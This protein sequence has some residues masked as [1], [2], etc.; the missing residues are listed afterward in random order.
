MI[1]AQIK[2][3]IL[4]ILTAILVTTSVFVALPA[5]VANAAVTCPAGFAEIPGKDTCQATD[6]TAKACPK[7]FPKVISQAPLLQCGK[8]AINPE[9][10]KDIIAKIQVLTGIQKLMNKIIWPVLVLTG[11]LMDNSLLFGN[12]MEEQL[13]NIWIPIRNLVNIFFVIL[14]VGIAL[15]NVLGIGDENSEYAVKSMLPKIVIGIIAVNFSFLAIKVVLDAINILTV[16]IFAL[17]NQVSEGLDKVIEFDENGDPTSKEHKKIESLCAS[18]S[19]QGYS[20]YKTTSDIVRKQEIEKKI[21]HSVLKKVT[22]QVGGKTFKEGMTLEE[23]K[24]FAKQIPPKGT[25][26]V[27]AKAVID[28]Q[29]AD[30]IDGNLC[31]EQKKLTPTGKEFLRSYNSRN[32]AFAMAL[33]MGKIVFYNEVNWHGLE[34]IDK[35]FINA[36]MSMLLY[37]VYVASFLALF[38]V[39][40]GRM[41]VM[42]LSIAVSPILVLLLGSSGIKEKVGDLGKLVDQFTKNAIAPVLIALSMTI[43]WIMLKAIQDS[44]GMS[45]DSAL[46]VDLTGGIPV[47]GLNTLQDFTVAVGTIAVVWLGVFSAASGTIAEGATNWMKDNLLKAGKYVGSI[48]FKHVPFI[49]MTVNG[50]DQPITL[51][52]LGYAAKRALDTDAADTAF[53]DRIAPRQEV[54]PRTLNSDR[55]HNV[56]TLKSALKALSDKGQLN[57]AETKAELNK[58]KT[59]NPALYIK[60]TED[61]LIGTHIKNL[62]D[63][64]DA[65]REKAATALKRVLAGTTAMTAIDKDT[66]ASKPEAAPKPQKYKAIKP[67]DQIQTQDNTGKEEDNAPLSIPERGRLNKNLSALATKLEKPI[68][69][70]DVDTLVKDL[71]VTDVN[72]TKRALTIKSLTEKLGQPRVDNLIQAYGGEEKLK[73]ALKSGLPQPPAG[74]PPP[75]APAGTTPPPAQP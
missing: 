68:T 11:G 69:L 20:E 33:N 3:S 28:K 47:V 54:T 56:P 74:T 72:D 57:S 18:L 51:S 17:P 26:G 2:K 60:A 14:L 10:S 31:N 8:N 66:P 43:G 39:L 48:P 9:A 29:I 49:P 35:L 46:R 53:W 13:R 5:N 62:T 38:I 34:S 32:A 22:G 36:L 27:P 59:N 65:D 6:A 15:Y 42:W 7:E 21:Y 30:G 16:S 23:L 73:A 25:N 1:K 44:N 40:L 61:T 12:G 70:K 58:L 24:D 37:L 52:Q 50:S 41:V 71:V 45:S 4:T 55:V 75:A 67:K 63:G 64:D 19:G